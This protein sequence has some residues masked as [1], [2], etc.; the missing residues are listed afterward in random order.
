MTDY[1]SVQ[2]LIVKA[3]FHDN[4]TITI[5][6]TEI[7]GARDVLKVTFSKGDYYSDA[8]IDL[9]PGYSDPEEAALYSCRKALYDLFHTPYEEIVYKKENDNV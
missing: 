3:A 5:N 6:A 8:Y 1:K 9:C 4:I 7:I 2:D